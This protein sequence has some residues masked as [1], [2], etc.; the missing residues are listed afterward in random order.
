MQT[1]KYHWYQTN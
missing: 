1:V